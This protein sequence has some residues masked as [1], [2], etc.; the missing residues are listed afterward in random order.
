MIPK[1][2]IISKLSGFFHVFLFSKNINLKN[3]SFVVTSEA[4]QSVSLGEKIFKLFFIN[5]T[6]CFVALAMTKL[7]FKIKP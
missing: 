2:L 5:P 1:T 4:W 6:D 3:M 7:K